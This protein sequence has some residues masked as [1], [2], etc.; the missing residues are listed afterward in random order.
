MQ[1]SGHGLPIAA[2]RTALPRAW[3]AGHPAPSACVGSSG[4]VAGPF[5]EG[6]VRRPMP[7]MPK[8]LGCGHSETCKKAAPPNRSILESLMS[9]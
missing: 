5:S 3:P 4:W 8:S 2:G 6:C 7:S 1:L 9:D